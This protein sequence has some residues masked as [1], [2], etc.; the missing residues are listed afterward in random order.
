MLTSLIGI[1][2]QLLIGATVPLPPPAEV[3]QSLQSA[4]VINDSESGDGFQLTFALTKD[5]TGDF[6]L[7]SSGVLDAFTRVIIGV[8]LGLQLQV[9]IDGI[10]T[11]HELTPSDQPGQSTLTVT[12]KDVSV[13]MDL[14]ERNLPFPNQSDS[15]I[16]QQIVGA[17]SQYGLQCA[18]TP[19]GD[20]PIELQRTPRQ[21][22]TDLAAVKRLARRNGYIFY[23][24]PTAPQVNLAFF[25]PDLRTGAPQPGLRIDMG[26]ATNLR[27]LNFSLDAMAPELAVG[28]Y[29]DPSS[30]TSVPIPSAPSL[31]TP[32]LAANPVT[33]R[34][35]RYL[36]DSANYDSPMALGSS[37]AA[38]SNAPDAVTGTGEV[39]SIRY[40]SVLRARGLVGVAGAGRTYDG[41]Y[42]VRRV[43]HD[44]QPHG[45]Y[46]QS[47]SISREG[48]GALLPMVLP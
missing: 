12:G 16:V 43:T 21:A 14:E 22:E 31:R 46:R 9:L 38:V 18:A 30:M 20:Q 17:Y 27:S 24:Q 8:N 25:G 35:T 4:R 26:Q 23:V 48:T 41:F 13:M 37:V 5:P 3:M 10:I 47:F 29:L 2:L 28:S 39:D 11:N 19:T 34:R 7:L 44:L 45:S 40:G 33:A 36:R 42:Y 15:T 32:P 6:S 1:R